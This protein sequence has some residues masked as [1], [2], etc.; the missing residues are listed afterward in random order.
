MTDKNCVEIYPSGCVRY[1][2]K[3]KAGQLLETNLDCNPGLNEVV[4]LFDDTLSKLVDKDGIDKLTL[5]Q[6]NSACSSAPLLALNG[7]TVEEGKYYSSEVVLQLVAVICELKSRLN[8]LLI[9]NPATTSGNTH[10][11]DLALSSDFKVWMQ[12]NGY[13]ECLGNDPCDAGQQI[14]TLGTLLQALIKKICACCNEII[15]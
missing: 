2:G 12:Q 9:E 5:D 15:Q 11:E 14:L 13:A 7:I 10:W 1:T 6:A 4:E 8:Y 3:Q